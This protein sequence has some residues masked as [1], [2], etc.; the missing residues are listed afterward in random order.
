M[1]VNRT[2]SVCLAGALALG[3]SGLGTSAFAADMAVK[4]PYKAP[5]PEGL[6]VHGFV[7]FSFKNDY[8]TPRGLLVHNTGLATQIL[9]GLVW[10]IY[11]SKTGFINGVSVY[12]YVWN[13]LWSKQNDAH[14]GSWNE[15][16]WAVGGV[17][18]FADKWKLTVEYIEFLPP[19]H[20]LITS[21][22][23]I[24]RNIEI[25]L[26]YDDSHWWGSTPFAIN[27]Y[28]K[29][30]YETS[31]PSTVVLGKNG[32]IYDVEL[33]IVPTYDFKKSTGVALTVSAPTWITVG[34]SNYWN[35]NVF[36]TGDGSGSVA[37]ITTRF[38]GGASNFCGPLSE[39]A[40]STDSA[41]VFSTGLTGKLSLTP[42][43]PQRLGSWYVKGGF[44]YYHIINDALLAAQMFTSAAS[45]TANV[46]GT[47]QQTHRDVTVGFIGTGMTF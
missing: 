27:P 44:Q 4:A 19:A 1:G 8:I 9:G 32:G 24:E 37:N 11:K 17:V 2:A 40:C 41:G 5:E 30:F 39:S 25:G 23:S 10:D 42:Y 34:P 28:V 33:G 45:K 47:Y 43:V 18:K 15:F 12:S 29:L 3:L 22:P 26:F 21:F 6:D 16:D 14:V 13:D 46:Y 31:G 36:I 35:K 38:F 7:D 20:D